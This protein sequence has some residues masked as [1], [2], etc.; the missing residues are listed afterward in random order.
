MSKER[1][2]KPEESQKQGKDLGDGC[3][4]CVAVSQETGI[5]LQRT[6]ARLKKRISMVRACEVEATWPKSPLNWLESVGSCYSWKY[7]QPTHKWLSFFR[8]E[9]SGLPFQEVDSPPVDGA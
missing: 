3:R 7:T 2:R 6:F 1:T 9:Q 4:L 5:Q 8:N